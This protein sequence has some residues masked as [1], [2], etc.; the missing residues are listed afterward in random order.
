MECH[1]RPATSRDAAAISCVVIAALRESNSQDY[2][3]D[4]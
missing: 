3:P 2:P 1:V 4:V